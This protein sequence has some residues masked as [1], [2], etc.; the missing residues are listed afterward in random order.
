MTTHLEQIQILYEIAM[1]IGT[2]LDI[3]EMSKKSLSSLIGKLNCSAGE[4]YMLKRGGQGKNHFETISSMPGSKGPSTIFQKTTMLPES[5]D[6]R[7]W[8]SFRNRLPIHVEEKS[9]SYIYILELP[10]FGVVFLK[11]MGS[12]F[13]PFVIMSLDSILSK[14]AAACNNCLRN[15][16]LEEIHRVDKKITRELKNK[17]SELTESR[18]A[19]MNMMK[20]MRQVEDELRKSKETLEQ[21]VMERTRELKEMQSQMVMQEK[22]ASVGQLAAGIAHELN[23]PI[24]FVR[25]NFATLA[26][27]FT[28]LANVLGDYRRLMIENKIQFDSPSELAAVLA[29][30]KSL[31]IDFIMED[32]PAI[33]EESERGF[34]RIA[35][36]N[37]SM[38][39]YSYVNKSRNLSYFNINKCIKDTLVI[40]KN[41]YKYHADVQTNMGELP[42]IPCFPGQLSQVFLNLIVNGAQ[43]IETRQGTNKG[44]I[45]IRTW[46][47]ENHVCC[48]IEDNG[49]GMPKEILSHIFEPFFTTK[50]PGQGTG[51]GLSISYDIIVHKHKGELTVDCPEARRTVFII[52][53]PVNLESEEEPQ[54]ENGR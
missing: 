50:E 51:L 46:K 5:F 7:Q 49:P 1:S 28:D 34:E 38:R 15:R 54:D 4:I 41:L 26:E 52:R 2:S 17:T 39:D 42:E 11:K 18:I 29:K 21:G 36:I 13:D 23:N 20:D 16:E 25:T 35:R 40:A 14:L 10:E 37:Q 22:M 8:T 27:N 9:D 53:I 33:F 6:H 30:E 47:E 31:Q 43:S 32:I 44:L 24:N 45:T 19:L 12:D 3:N 48:E